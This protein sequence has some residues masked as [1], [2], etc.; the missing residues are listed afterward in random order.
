MIDD[1][2]TKDNLIGLALDVITEG[3]KANDTRAEFVDEVLKPNSAGIC[4]A[5]VSP[6]H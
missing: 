5:N 2:E 4:P 1:K 6:L 3:R